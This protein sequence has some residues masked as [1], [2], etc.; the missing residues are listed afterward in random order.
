MTLP[1][2]GGQKKTKT[3]LKEIA[4]PLVGLVG[5]YIVQDKTAIQIV[6]QSIIVG[7]FATLVMAA[8]AV[9]RARLKKILE[10]LGA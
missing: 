8:G 4:A 3:Y 10:E 6:D 9:L 7:I 5:L 1:G 2:P